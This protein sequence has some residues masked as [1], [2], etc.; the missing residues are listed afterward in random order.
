MSAEIST[1]FAALL[2]NTVKTQVESG[3]GYCIRLY[4]SPRR[5][6]PQ[7]AVGAATLLCT[8]TAGGSGLT[9]QTAVDQLLAKTVSE[10]WESNNVASDTA[11]WGCHSPI[12]DTGDAST[13]IHR[14]DFDVGLWTDS[15]LPDLKMSNN[16]LVSGEPTRINQAT[17][18]IVKSVSEL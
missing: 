1:I 13:T 3:G 17:Y 5:A 18:T 6:T 4:S 10:V 8:V 7:D 14:I 16:V 12:T 15:P 2:A 11:I 9:W